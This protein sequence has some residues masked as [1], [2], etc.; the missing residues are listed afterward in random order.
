MINVKFFEIFKRLIKYDKKEDIFINGEDNAYPERVDRLINNSVTAK[1]ASEIMV[2]YLIGKGFGTETDSLIIN[3]EKQT[4]L[5]DFAEQI[6]KELVDN[7]G[8]FIHVGYEINAEANIIPVNPKVLPFDWCRLGKEDSK[9]YSGKIHVKSDW[10]DSKEEA[11]I[12]DVYN[13]IEKVIAEQISKAGGIE[14]YTGQIFYYNPDARSHYPLS[15]IDAV[16][17][18][19]DSEAQSSVYKNQ[20][21]REGFFGK[22]MIITRPLVD[23]STPDTILDDSG[24]TIPNPAYVDMQSEAEEAEKE[25]ENFLGAGNAGGAMLVQ[26]DNAG[27]SLED[28]IRIENITADIDPD[29]FQ[30][31][32]SSIRSNILIAFKNL[33]IGLVKSNEGL[34]SNS[35]E[36]IEEMKRTYWENTDKERNTFLNLLNIFSKIVIEQ[37][38]NVL[39]LIETQEV[40]EDERDEN[41]IA[42]AQLRGSVGGVTALLAIQQSVAAGTTTI[43]SGIAMIINIYGFSREV[44]TQMLGNPTPE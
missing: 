3:T 33:P 43:D 9:R 40:Q 2:Q 39:P 14:K 28:A 44:A 22:T 11:A 24:N 25:I 1:M 20:L 37:E 41:A 32:E 35:G 34:F 4:M 19:C 29:M 8:V 17:G 30:G 6:A 27:D 42:Q 23:D 7:R 38:L 31:V 12:F 21:L 18:D 26:L 16:L 36:A 13:P 15:R 5:I 10:R